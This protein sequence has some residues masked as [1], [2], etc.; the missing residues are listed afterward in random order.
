MSAFWTLHPSF[1]NPSLV[2]VQAFNLNTLSGDHRSEVIQQQAIITHP[3]VFHPTSSPFLVVLASAAA[4][5]SILLAR[6]HSFGD[7]L[8]L[9][10]RRAAPFPPPLSSPSN[11]NHSRPV[12][13][14]GP[15]NIVI[16]RMV[17]L[18][19]FVSCCLDPP[20][21]ELVCVLLCRIAL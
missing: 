7:A 16:L 17:F 14:D 1:S 5:Y 13:H 20:P 8:C 12:P 11:S 4:T 9:Q 3:E 10:T 15:F 21:S 19:H 2:L 18:F 6:H